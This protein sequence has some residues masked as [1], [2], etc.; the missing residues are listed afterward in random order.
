MKA[1]PTR[2]SAHKVATNLQRV[3]QLYESNLYYAFHQGSVSATTTCISHIWVYFF[4]QFAP[5][6]CEFPV[7]ALNWERRVFQVFT[8]RSLCSDLFT[9]F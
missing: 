3:L 5:D 9:A 1:E 2:K 7:K 8:Y 4:A 6:S